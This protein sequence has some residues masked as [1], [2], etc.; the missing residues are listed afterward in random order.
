MTVPSYTTFRKLFK[1]QFPNV[2][3]D[4]HHGKSDSKNHHSNVQADPTTP[5]KDSDKKKI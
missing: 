4:P 1:E 3:L 2:R 5:S